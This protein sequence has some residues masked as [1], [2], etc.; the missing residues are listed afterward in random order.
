MNIEVT[1][2]EMPGTSSARGGDGLEILDKLGIT[3]APVNRELRR[4]YRIDSDSGL[5]ITKVAQRSDAHSTGLSEGDVIFEVNNTRVNSVED[6]NKA[7]ANKRSLA[8][9]VWRDG[10]TFYVPMRMPD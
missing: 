6:L 10:K 1:L 3:V 2:G 9:L 4:Q 7:V 5:V 8:F